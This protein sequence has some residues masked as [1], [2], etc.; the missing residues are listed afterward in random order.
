MCAADKFISR[1]GTSKIKNAWS[2][3]TF[4]VHPLVEYR[5]K[6][7]NFFFL[8]KIIFKSRL[9][10]ELVNVMENSLSRHIKLPFTTQHTHKIREMILPQ[11][12]FLSFFPGR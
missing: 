6:I 7:L 4:D 11:R 2:F 5:T 1:D 10:E 8:F 12:K 9:K 3:L